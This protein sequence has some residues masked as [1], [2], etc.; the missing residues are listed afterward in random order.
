M[1]GF[2][3][4]HDYTGAGGGVIVWFLFTVLII[5]SVI[6]FAAMIWRP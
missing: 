3:S 4:Y 6:V 1:T 5:L 2:P